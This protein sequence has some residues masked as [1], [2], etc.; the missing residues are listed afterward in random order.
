MRFGEVLNPPNKVAFTVPQKN[1][2]SIFR[3]EIGDI[4]QLVF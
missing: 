1:K 4:K 2:C 3:V